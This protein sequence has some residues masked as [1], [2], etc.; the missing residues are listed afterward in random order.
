MYKLATSKIRA[1]VVLRQVQSQVIVGRRVTPRPR[2]AGIWL[3]IGACSSACVRPAEVH[4][5]D[6]LDQRFLSAYPYRL[7]EHRPDCSS[8]LEIFL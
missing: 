1:A 4:S 7:L 2:P 8:S 6:I 5:F 3:S